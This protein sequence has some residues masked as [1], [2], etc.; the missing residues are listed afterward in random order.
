[1]LP[2]RSYINL[3]P[4]DIRG[5]SFA[6]TPAMCL[7]ILMGG[8]QNGKGGFFPKCVPRRARARRPVPACWRACLMAFP[9]APPPLPH[10]EPVHAWRTGL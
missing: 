3:I 4:T 7:N 9:S 1:M 10:T 2:R 8:A 5:V 6:R